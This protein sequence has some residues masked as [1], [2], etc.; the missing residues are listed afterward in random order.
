MAETLIEIFE[1]STR[2]YSD[3]VASEREVGGSGLRSFTYEEF[4]RRSRGVAQKLLDLGVRPGSRVGILSDNRPEWGIAFF[5]VLLAGGVVVPLDIRLKPAEI[6]NILERSEMHTC[7]VGQEALETLEEAR[8]SAPVLEHFFLMDSPD[9]GLLAKED[10]LPVTLNDPSSVAVISFSSGTTGTPKGVMLSHRNLAS[11]I[12]SVLELCIFDTEATLLSILPMHHAFELTAGF[13]TP[14]AKGV[15]V[16][17]LDAVSPK[18]ISLAL[19]ERNITICLVVPAL[20]RLFHKNIFSQV[21]RESGAKRFVFKLLFGISLIGLGMGLRLGKIIFGSLRKR[22]G[23][24]FRFFVSGGAAL[25]PKVQ[26]DLMALGLETLQ[27][28]GL[29]EASPITNVNPPKRNKIGTV[30]PAVPGVEVKLRAIEGGVPGEGEVLIRGPNIMLGYYEN[31]MATAEVLSD[32]WLCTGD[33]GR[34]DADGYLSICG[35]SKNVI[36]SEDGKNIYPEEIENEL[37][38]SAYFK[39]ICILGRPSGSGG[40]DIYAVIVPN[41]EIL[42]EEGETGRVEEIIAREV[43]EVSSRLADY[44]RI[45]DYTI[46]EED[47]PKTTTL[48]VKRQNLIKLLEERGLW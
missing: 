10:A 13:L 41:E 15:K 1:F 48:K 7:V 39:E 5:G 47:L 28:Y 2:E 8:T 24:N 42:V 25:D 38:K 35:R 4:G 45:R 21:K 36:I 6:A 22:F 23:E 17:Y 37:S 29:T 44:K 30:G 18:A 26:R 14:F 43:K 3:R 19:A 27:G 34:L 9:F 11:N 33:I 31:P 46:L 40:E 12:T 16:S 32:G 20:L